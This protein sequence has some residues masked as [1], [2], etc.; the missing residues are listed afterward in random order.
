MLVN[1]FPGAPVIPSSAASAAA[2]V[3]VVGNASATGR[4]AGVATVHVGGTDK[5]PTLFASPRPADT[6][7]AGAA[8]ASGPGFVMIAGNSVGGAD[9]VPGQGCTLPSR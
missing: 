5:A 2:A 7:D 6:D 3:L 4:T 8:A 9:P 1:G